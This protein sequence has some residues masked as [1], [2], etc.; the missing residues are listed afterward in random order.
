MQELTL[1][2]I[3]ALNNGRYKLTSNDAGDIKSFLNIKIVSATDKLQWTVEMVYMKRL[4][5]N[6]ILRTL[7]RR[8]FVLGLGIQ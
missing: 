2:R 3:I 8:P 4:M 1:M 7:V 5:K 6:N